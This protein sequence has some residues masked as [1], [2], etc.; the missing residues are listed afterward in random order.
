[1]FC[2]ELS[3]YNIHAKTDDF[4]LC[5]DYGWNML[6]HT[7]LAASKRPHCGL[8]VGTG[9]SGLLLRNDNGFVRLLIRKLRQYSAPPTIPTDIIIQQCM[10]GE[11]D[12][13]CAL[14]CGYGGGMVA[15]SR[16]IMRHLGY[17]VSTMSDRQYDSGE[18]Q[19]GW[20]QPFN[21]HPLVYSPPVPGK[22]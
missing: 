21:W 3:C 5:H 7:I 20:R 19:C 22:L 8:F 1:M 11:L 13:E 6:L 2:R 15:S 9:G 10:L 17:A 18:F 12:E 4:E 16:L 14:L